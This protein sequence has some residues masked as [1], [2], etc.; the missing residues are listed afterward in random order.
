MTQ[1]AASIPSLGRA[2]AS[3]LLSDDRLAQRATKG[4]RRA[5][6]AIYQR[7]H[8]DLYRFCLAIVGNAQDAQDA[9][10]ST[11]VKVLRALPG[12][13]RRIQLKPWLYRIA[14]NEAIELLRKRRDTDQIE[15]ELTAAPGELAETADLRDRLR[16]LIA[17]LGELPERQRAALVMRELSGLGFAR[18]GA[19]FD[20]SPAVA[21]QTVYEA[22]LGLRQME[23]GREMSCKKAMRA[24]SDADGR[25]IRRR[26]IRAHLR[27]CPSCRGFRDGLT[28]RRRDLAALAPLPLAASAGLLQGILGGGQAGTSGGLAGALGAGA[29]KAAATS[30]VVK[31]VATVAVVATVGVS[32][33]DRGGLVDVGLPGGGG[34]SRSGSESTP[35]P[36]SNG[37]P[38]SRPAAKAGKPAKASRAKRR[39]NAKRRAKGG[40][41]G[42]ATAAPAES[43]PGHGAPAVPAERRGPPEGLPEASSHGQQTASA[44]RGGADKKPR[45]RSRPAPSRRGRPKAKSPRP[46]PARKVK[47]DK[48]KGTPL[49]PS[50]RSNKSASA[51]GSADSSNAPKEAR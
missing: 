37:E 45:A 44:R 7:Y 31:S 47:P 15:P 30:A 29:G 14:H 28:G 17:D 13:T 23:A 32:A 34:S 49:K 1:A 21:R 24:L 12:E 20:T 46:S 19:A 51:S 35:A 27:A 26:D 48:T 18:I 41:R 36:A 4:D 16:R 40:R 42:A 22:R 10:Q 3:R 50:K 2:G 33:A 8:Q 39:A 43:A 38:E 5:F 11:M 9:L 25:V 6:A